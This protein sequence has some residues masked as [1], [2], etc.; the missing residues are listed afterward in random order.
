MEEVKKAK[1]EDPELFD[2]QDTALSNNE[3][4]SFCSKNKLP[5]KMIELKDVPQLEDRY[6]FIFTGEDKDELNEG[7]NKHWLL[8]DGNLVFDS[9]GKSNSYKFPEQFK[10]IKNIPKQ[11]QEFNSVVC[12]QYCLAFLKFLI[13]NPDLKEKDLASEFS[14]LHDFNNDRAGNDRKVLD[15]YEK[16]K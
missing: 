12:G 1:R 16:H 10:F 6:S 9:Y 4:A 14:E 5:Y 2:M 8:V 7:N 11:L 3:L 15:W 13:D